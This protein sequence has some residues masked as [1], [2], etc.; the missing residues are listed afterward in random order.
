MASGWRLLCQ[1]VCGL[2]GLNTSWC[3][4]PAASCFSGI[5]GLSL[6]TFLFLIISN[7]KITASIPCYRFCIGVS[8]MQNS[9]NCMLLIAGLWTHIFS[10]G[11]FLAIAYGPIKYA[12]P[13]IRDL[14]VSLAVAM[15]F[16]L[17]QFITAPC[18]AQYLVLCRKS[19]SDCK[20]IIV[21]YFLPAISIAIS[22][23]YFSLFIPYPEVR[24][25]IRV[26]AA[27]VQHLG[28][29]DI[30]EV[31]GIGMNADP[32]NG[33]VPLAILAIPFSAFISF[34][35]T[36][37][38]LNNLTLML[39]FSL[40]TLPTVQAL[41]YIKFLSRTIHAEH[42][43]NLAAAAAVAS[44]TDANHS[45]KRMAGDRRVSVI[46]TNVDHAINVAT[47]ASDAVVHVI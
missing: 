19:M 5:V 14:V 20:R 41:V 3:Y 16:S 32:E 36:E 25:K 45:A 22:A 6:N 44:F 33:F 8:A 43:H 30:Y 9:F 23:P 38:N 37:A 46:S 15:V 28:E 40:W 13:W 11:F 7:E 26:I 42:H 27:E 17:W 18:I 24:D 34:I 31:Y 10:E 39:T 12:Q 4:F 21:A 1:T 47:V 35:I 2:E 29:D